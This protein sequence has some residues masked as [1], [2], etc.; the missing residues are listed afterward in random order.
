MKISGLP[1]ELRT[2]PVKRRLIAAGVAGAVVIVLVIASGSVAVTGAAVTLVGAWWSYPVMVFGASLIGLIV[3]SYIDAP[4][5]GEA[6]QCDVRWPLLGLF[7]LYFTTEAR[8]IVP[9]IPDAI[10]PVVAAAALALLVWALLERLG[11]EH[12]AVAD[13]GESGEVCTT[14]KPLFGAARARP[15]PAE[16]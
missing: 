16:R 2:W 10:R 9:L 14:C 12:R 6:T 4:I 7:A 15:A 11:S 13:R 8:E 3:A 5:G 1:T